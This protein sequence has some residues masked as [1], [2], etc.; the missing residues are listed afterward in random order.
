MPIFATGL[1]L[2][3]RRRWR[4]RLAHTAATCDKPRAL[5]AFSSIAALLLSVLLLIGG[6]A[7]VGVTTPLRAR[8]DG[9]PDLVVGLL[10]SVRASPPTFL[11]PLGTGSFPEGRGGTRLF[12]A[13]PFGE[14]RNCERVQAHA[15][16]LGPLGEL[17]VQRFGRAQLPFSAVRLGG[18]D[19]RRRDRTAG[20]GHRRNPARLGVL[21]VGDGFLDRL[22]IGHAAGQIREFNEIPAAFVIAQGAH[23]ESIVAHSSLALTASISATK[24][25]MYTGLIAR[26]AGTE[27]ASANRG[28][29]NARLSHVHSERRGDC[30][31]APD[32]PVAR[33][34]SHCFERLVG[35]RH[36]CRPLK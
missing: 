13:E 22:P 21:T 4:L 26:R 2:F 29:S 31:K 5:S 14:Q 30:F 12:R 11:A 9:F 6:N 28:C 32:P 1:H 20:V 3:G 16:T 36:A 19:G 25:R 8:I 33:I 34:R 15:F 7:L 27:S 23:S 17:P 18:L 10:G 24:R 35:P